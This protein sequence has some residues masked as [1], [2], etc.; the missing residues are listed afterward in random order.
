MKIDSINTH[1]NLINEEK[2]LK[3]AMNIQKEFVEQILNLNNKIVKMD[4]QEKVD[5]QKVDTLA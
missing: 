4:I 2:A 1:Y 3:E 5:S